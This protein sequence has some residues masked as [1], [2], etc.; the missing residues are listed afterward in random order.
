MRFIT[1][2][3]RTLWRIAGLIWPFVG[4]GFR[5]SGAGTLWT[6][7]FLL[8][9]LGFAVAWLFGF[10]PPEVSA[11]LDS[12]ADLWRWIGDWLW[13]GFWGVVLL[14]CAA[15]LFAIGLEWFGQKA[16]GFENAPRDVKGG[17]CSLIG[18]TV[19]GYVAWIA[20][21]MPLS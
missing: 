9:F 18:V 5:L 15:I 13:R 6:F 8:F 20:I 16:K 10:S 7:V 14:F 17:C 3:F 19:A 11:W 21:T 1:G 4:S 12:H 2:F